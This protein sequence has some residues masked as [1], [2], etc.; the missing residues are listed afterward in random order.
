[1][2]VEGIGSVSRQKLSKVINSSKGGITPEA[3]CKILNVSR[4]EAGRLLSRWHKSG[5]L[6]RIKRGFYISIPVES[7]PDRLAIE[8][9]WAIV[10]KIFSPG[11]IGGF[12]AIKHW[13]LSEQIFESIV[14]YTTKKVTVR[15]PDYSGL[16]LH[17]KTIKSSKLFGT[18]TIWIDS[19]KVQVSDPTRTMVD[20]FDDP[21]M[22]GGM[23]IVRD[24]FQNYLESEHANIKLLMDYSEKFGNNTVF[25]RLGFLME[26]IGVDNSKVLE[27]I[28]KKISKGY[29]KFDPSVTG[30]RIIRRWNLI[31]PDSWMEEYD[32]KK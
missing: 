1:M 2:N 24:F 4:Q 30:K 29:S 10:S 9:P 7:A 32:R 23:S 5:W 18:K 27:R 6:Q 12:S 3:V 22:V 16:K 31:V 8:N 15:H 17:L 26:T 19:I 21:A 11:Y 13:D 20:L 25:K 14:F 28:R